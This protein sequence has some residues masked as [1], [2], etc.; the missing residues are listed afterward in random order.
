M[1]I[2][3]NW[4]FLVNTRKICE[5]N[6]C[7]STPS[8]CN[9]NPHFMNQY[10]QSTYRK[11]FF[12]HRIWTSIDILYSCTFYLHKLTNMNE[13]NLKENVSATEWL[14]LLVSSALIRTTQDAESSINFLRHQTCF[15]WLE[16]IQIGSELIAILNSRAVDTRQAIFPQSS[17]RCLVFFTSRVNCPVCWPELQMQWTDQ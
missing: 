10:N 7:R 4:F 15:L 3:S 11:I 2:V 12:C 17:K 5:S 16:R 6:S 9:V 14:W 1:Y 8:V 13:V